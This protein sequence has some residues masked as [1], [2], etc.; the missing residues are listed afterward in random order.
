MSYSTIN[1]KKCKC[2]TKENPCKQYPTLGYGGYNFA[3]APEEIKERVGEKKDFQ[4][5]KQNTRKAISVKLRAENRKKDESA[6]ETY[7][8]AWF[9]AR[10][11]EMTGFCKCGCGNRSSRDDE[12]NFRS[13]ACHILP[14]R[15]FP[16]IQFHPKNFIEMAFWGGCHTNFDERGSDRWTKLDCWEEIKEKFLILYPL[17]DQKEYQF[18]P[19]QL[20]DL[21]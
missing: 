12:A 18:I 5:K 14:Q 19:K 10:R 16:S 17:I 7:K 13:S 2:G 4:R 3:H 6:G 9:R 20:S 1:K 15:N 11:R 8:E 21:L